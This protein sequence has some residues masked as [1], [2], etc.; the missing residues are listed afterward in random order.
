M[1][2]SGKKCKGKKLEKQNLIRLR[3]EKTEERCW[4]KICRNEKS[5]YAKINNCKIEKSRDA[6]ER[7]DAKMRKVGN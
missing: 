3:N 1:V 7:R 6:N 4:C 2:Y 5:I